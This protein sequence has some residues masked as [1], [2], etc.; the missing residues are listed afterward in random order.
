MTDTLKPENENQILDAIQWAVSEKTPL[1]DA[2]GGD[3]RHV[4]NVGDQNL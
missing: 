1:D 3:P 2:D 4:G